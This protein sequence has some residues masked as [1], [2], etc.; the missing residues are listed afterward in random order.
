MSQ[1]IIKKDDVELCT[2]S[3]GNPEDPCILL[4]MGATAS[5]VWWDEEFCQRLSNH[6]RFVIRYDNRDVGCSTCYEPGN[7]Q[8]TVPDMAD[9]AI[10]ILDEYGIE[11]AHL[12]GMSLGGM[13]AQIIA[14]KYSNRVISISAIAS[15]IWDD[16]PELPQTDQKILEYHQKASSLDWNDQKAVIEYMAGGW[17]LLSGSAHPFDEKRALRLAEI[18]VKRAKSFLSMFNHA[19]LKGGEELYGQA[20]QIKVPFLII[21]G[22]EDPVLP[23]IHAEVMHN[24]IKHSELLRL[25]GSGHE[26]HYAE[27][28]R[29]I[30]AILKHTE[31]IS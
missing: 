30:A 26:I 20:S 23:F 14:I 18:E 28:D 31:S 13:I 27:W 2:E 21:H 12:V 22:T 16:L 11:R 5:M 10:A 25:E 8:Y 7:P 3:F 17:R 19:L 24:T 15:G 1:K 29:I 6:H 9:D 4:I